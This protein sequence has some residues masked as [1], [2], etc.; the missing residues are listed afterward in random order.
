MDSGLDRCGFVDGCF[1]WGKKRTCCALRWISSATLPPNFLDSWP[2]LRLQMH[3]DGRRYPPH[4]CVHLGSCAVNF[5]LV[6][7][8][9]RM[10]FSRFHR[11]LRPLVQQV[12]PVVWGSAVAVFSAATSTLAQTNTGIA[13]NSLGLLP[14]YGE[15]PPTFWEQHGTAIIIAGI[16]G[17]ALVAAGLWWWLQPRPVEIPPPEKQAREALERLLQTPEDG[18]ILSDI[19]AILHRYFRDA[20]GLPAG[21]LTTSEFCR[22]LS[23]RDQIGP[24]L[25]SAV[26]GFLRQGD[27][28]KFALLKAAEP[29][30]AA[31]RALQLVALGEA[32]RAQLRQSTTAEPPLEIGSPSISSR[33]AGSKP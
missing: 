10:K 28:R 4:I 21:E 13:T 31:A 15:L 24:E 1:R 8:P 29:L 9:G 14:P 5:P 7:A 6:A 12:T 18:A 19:S 27:E 22:A 17:L 25:A 3:A 23:S 30:G 2:G 33:A 32:R 26:G 11:W 16:L 20:F